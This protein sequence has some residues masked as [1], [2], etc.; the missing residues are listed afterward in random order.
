MLQD[1]ED[2]FQFP[3]KR[4]VIQ[5]AIVLIKEKNGKYTTVRVCTH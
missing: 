4:P 5:A 3:S 2:V 1:E